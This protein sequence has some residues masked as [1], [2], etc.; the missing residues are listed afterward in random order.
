MLT[1]KA[2]FLGTR[3]CVYPT[4]W[5]ADFK[6]IQFL[7]LFSSIAKCMGTYSTYFILFFPH[8]M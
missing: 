3:E 4:T 6:D 7:V 2:Y 1:P 8:A 5:A